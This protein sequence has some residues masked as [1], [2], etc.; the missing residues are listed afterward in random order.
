MADAQPA[1]RPR[2]TTLAEQWLDTMLELEPELHVHLGRPG[3]ESDYA[4]RSPDGHAAAADAAA[5]ML[6]PRRD[7]RR[8]PT[9]S[10]PSPRPS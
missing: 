9:T 10:T 3:R 8:R 7:A 2:S 4:D 6:A 5:A 1:P